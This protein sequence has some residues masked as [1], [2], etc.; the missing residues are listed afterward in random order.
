M[1]VS[2]ANAIPRFIGVDSEGIGK[3]KNHRAVL[4]GVGDRQ[5]L[6]RD[7]TIG[8]VWDE[9]FEFLYAQFVENRNAAFVGFY[10]SY[11]FNQWLRSLPQ[12]AAR[13][14]LTKAG[15]LARRTKG[16]RRAFNPVKVGRWEV[17]MLGFRR[18]S[19]RP[20]PEGCECYE[21][22]QKCTHK[23]LPWMHISDAGPFY[24]MAFI[25]VIDPSRWIDDADGAVCT[26][27]EYDTV[28]EGKDHL[29]GIS[30]AVFWRRIK[31]VEYYNQLENI[32]LARVME[33]LAKGFLKV[34]VRLNKDQWYGPGSSAAKWLQNN[35]G[36]K[37]EKLRLKQGKKP[38]L[39][40]K[41]FWD[42]SQA[43][44][45][46]G[47][48]E[49]FSH[50][51]I[52]GES[53]NYDINNAYPF[54]ATMLPHICR[55][56]RFDRGNGSYRGKGTFVLLYATVYSRQTRIGAVPYRA[57]DGSILRPRV[58]KG[59]YWQFEIEASR[60][61]GLVDRVLTH[62]WVEYI[63]CGHPN[64][65][66][67]IRDLYNLRLEVGKDSA[68]GMAI[69]LNNNSIYGKFAQS[70]GA[71]PYNNWFY[72]SYITAHCR[73]QILGAIA[74]H[75]D[76]SDAILMVATD[77]ICFDSPN[78]TLSISRE[79]GQWAYVTYTDVCLFKPG[80]YWH[81]EG[82]QALLK[83][84]SR[85]VPREE[86]AKAISLAERQFR[87]MLNN[88]QF[89]QRT[90]DELWIECEG[91]W[92]KIG[93]EEQW[94]SFHVPVN[95]RM[96]SCVQALNEGNWTAAGS[97]Q[98]KAL[99]LQDSDPYKKRRRPRF[100]AEKNR[101]DTEIHDLPKEE[102]QT[103]YH[104]EIEWPKVKG[105]GFEFEGDAIG[106]ILEA[107]A[108]LRDKPANY[109]LPIDEIEWITVWDGG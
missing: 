49:I 48:F 66:R 69:K 3:G 29:R 105:L 57:K 41:W 40:P 43:S 55:E 65:F 59:W 50:G 19:I 32:L 36:I 39:M 7:T 31:D 64:P 23:H 99:I 1:R 13:Q 106:P 47:W 76:K 28:K 107:A 67:G 89:P 8:L 102:W 94:P 73:A 80:V 25:K 10:L 86:F 109:D 53:Y 52:L 42:A 6:A 60:K 95:F 97:I 96:K 11:D 62:Q 22:A 87:D 4:L 103:K 85:G 83:V 9:V 93:K 33:R 15:R 91:D 75:P 63:P 21:K 24:Q 37:R 56:G 81:K 12:S 61:A 92:M 34:G 100:N 51:L 16:K 17:D 78:P 5:Y 46:G 84:K 71:A 54:A 104:G 26:K 18:L 58:S 68:Q 35:G 72:A 20:R 77:G 108:I 70:V 88:G 90:F 2:R 101:I 82:K 14:L 30:E 74:T 45:F 44:Y 27:A 98:E 79:L 38:A